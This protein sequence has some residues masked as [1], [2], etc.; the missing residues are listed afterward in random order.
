MEA[1]TWKSGVTMGVATLLGAFIA[2]AGMPAVFKKVPTDLERTRVLISAVRAIQSGSLESPDIVLLGNSVTMNGVDADLVASRMASKPKIYNFSSTGQSVAESFL[3]FQELPAKTKQVVLVVPTRNLETDGLPPKDVANAFYMNG[4]RVKPSTQSVLN[5][6]F[7]DQA[8]ML[9]RNDVEQR[10]ASR[11]VL[12]QV[13]DTVVRKKL[14]KDMETSKSILSLSYPAPYS[15]K[16]GSAEF[17]KLLPSYESKREPGPFKPLDQQVVMIRKMG[18]Q[19]AGSGAKLWVVFAP[20]NPRR[21]D[22]LGSKYVES[23][24]TFSQLSPFGPDAKILDLTS[25]LGADDFIDVV[26]PTRAGAEKISA[27]IGEFLE[28]G[29]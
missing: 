12:S 2:F 13:V 19:L 5:S 9:Q 28:R 22:A 27:R 11:W 20:L 15:K 23:V 6:V 18:E 29:F 21:F 3:Y 16:I 7:S 1:K 24:T 26:H 17:E 10:F 8:A 25:L 4:Y 14:R